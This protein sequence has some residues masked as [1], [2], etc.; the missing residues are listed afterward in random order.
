MSVKQSI[1]VLISLTLIASIFSAPSA[2][3]GTSYSFNSALAT[4]QNG[5]TQAQV[6]TAYTGTTLAGAVTVTTRGIQLWTVPATGSY[7]ITAVG[8]GGGGAAGGNGASM[9][10]TFSLSSGTT[11]KIVV[12]QTGVAVSDGGTYYRYGGGGG[13]YVTNSSNTAYIVAGGGGGAAITGGSYAPSY[14][15]N[16]STVANPSGSLG[17]VAGTG[18]SGCGGQGQGGGGL[19]GNGTGSPTSMSFTNNS[20]GGGGGAEQCPLTIGGTPYG[21]FG[22]GGAGGNG[23]GGGGGYYGGNGGDNTYT[24]GQYDS[25]DGG[26]SY[27]SGSNQSNVVASNRNTNG[28]VTITFVGSPTLSLSAAGAATQTNK[29]QTLTLTANAGQS[30]FVTFFADNKRIA[31]CISLSTSGGNVNCVWKA[32]V[33]TTIVLSAKLVSNGFLAATSSSLS[34]RVNRRSGTR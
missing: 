18:S 29:G 22:G 15:T 23:G 32:T 31:G 27:N 9:T 6:T 12:G 11:L 25:G 3:A 13:S 33:Q 24:S 8:A 17:G 4:G 2:F 26:G 21:G 30:G 7:Q 5:P 14:G 10:G 19:T 1:R 20:V 34:V 28:S 16:G